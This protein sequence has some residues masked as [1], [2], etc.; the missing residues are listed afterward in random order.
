MTP[1]K[2]L[3]PEDLAS[4]AVEIAKVKVDDKGG[5]MFIGS[6]SAEEFAE[7]NDAKNAGDAETKRNAAAVLIMKSLVKSETDATRIGTNSMVPLFRKARIART[8]RLLKA[9]LKLNGIQ[10]KDEAE[11][12][13]V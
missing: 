13:N 11:V 7:W 12:K 10:Q 1:E 4:E 9:V 2:V 8:E 5:V 6:L 3:T